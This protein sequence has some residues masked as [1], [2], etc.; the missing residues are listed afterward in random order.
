MKEWD[1]QS[2]KF[3]FSQGEGAPPSLRAEAMFSPPLMKCWLCFKSFKAWNISIVESWI[4][5][6][7]LGKWSSP[8]VF[9][10]RYQ[11]AFSSLLSCIC[12]GGS[13][14][15]PFRLPSQPFHL[16][17]FETNNCFISIFSKCKFHITQH[18]TTGQEYARRLFRINASSDV[19]QMPVSH[20]ASRLHQF[21]KE[22]QGPHV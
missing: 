3:H 9:R 2:K 14:W 4:K 19:L 21:S 6:G 13:V 20:S 11:R 15:N 17:V 16:D 12:G 8:L 1:T 10:Q 5:R 18:T 7:N 22:R